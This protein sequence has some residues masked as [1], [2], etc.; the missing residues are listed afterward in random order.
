MQHIAP[1]ALYAIIVMNSLLLVACQPGKRQESSAPTPSQATATADSSFTGILKLINQRV[2]LT[3]DYTRP[4]W[5]PDGSKL[6][7]TRRGNT[8]LYFIYLNEPQKIITLTEKQGAGYGAAWSADGKEVY[9]V[10]KENFR[11]VVKSISLESREVRLHPEVN[12]TSVKSFAQTGGKGPLLQLNAQ[13][14]QVEG[15]DP[16]TGE[17]WIITDFEGQFYEPLLSP[18]LQQVAVHRDAEIYVYHLRGGQRSALGRGIVASWSPDSRFLI[19]FLDESADGHRITNAELYLFAAD[20]SSVVKLTSSADIIEMWPSW[21]PARNEI[22]FT[23]AESGH[24]YIA[25]LLYGR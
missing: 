18:D 16:A 3:G 15:I 17:R 9:F 2:L 20:G 8:G 25:D 14:L 1:I 6:L 21:H 22:A 10:E 11:P 19:G 13:T 12:F 23:D 24:I 5:S 4:Q 7:F